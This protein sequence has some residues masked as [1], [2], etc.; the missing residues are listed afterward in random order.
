[1]TIIMTKK[2]CRCHRS[3]CYSLVFSKEMRYALKWIS[4]YRYY[5]FVMLERKHKKNC[6]ILLQHHYSISTTEAASGVLCSVLGSSTGER[7]GPSGMSTT[8]GLEAGERI[9]ASFL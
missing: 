9:G 1:M 8:K 6:G 2:C 4:F 5:I 7:H 3:F